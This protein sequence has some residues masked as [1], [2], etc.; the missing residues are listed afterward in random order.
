MRELRRQIRGQIRAFNKI[1]KA[2]GMEGLKKRINDYSSELEKEGRN[3]VKKLGSARQGKVWLH[4]PDMRTGLDRENS[5]IGGN[6][7]S[8]VRQINE[9][10][11]DITKLSSKLFID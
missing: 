2:E 11:N 4:E 9:M 6:A 7:L 8:I 10:S 3:Y 5:I 1:L